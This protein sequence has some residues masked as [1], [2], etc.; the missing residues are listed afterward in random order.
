MRTSLVAAILFAVIHARQRA[1]AQQLRILNP[2]GD[3]ESPSTQYHVIPRANTASGTTAHELTLRLG[4]PNITY[5]AEFGIGTPPQKIE[6]G[7]SSIALSSLR[8]HD[9]PMP[10]CD[11]DGCLHGTCKTDPQPSIVKI[12]TS[13]VTG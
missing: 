1:H 2:P 9:G 7:I 12:A 3:N 6:L 10:P 4:G 5:T 13:V 8:L 11:G